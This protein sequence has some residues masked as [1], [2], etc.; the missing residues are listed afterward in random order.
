MILEALASVS[1]A[2]AGFLFPEPWRQK[3]RTRR[4]RRHHA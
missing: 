3:L 2:I 1:D 4:A